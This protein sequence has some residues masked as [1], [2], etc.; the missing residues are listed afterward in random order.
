MFTKNDTKTWR[1]SLDPEK[2]AA[3]MAVARNSKQNQRQ[4]YTDR[5]TN[6]RKL[7]EERL[8]KGKEEKERRGLKSR[9]RKQRLVENIEEQ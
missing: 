5:R 2:K 8:M 1:D 9:V 7:R 4:K 3:V 6:I